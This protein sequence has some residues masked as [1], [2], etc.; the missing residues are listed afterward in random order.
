M[1]FGDSHGAPSQADPHD[2]LRVMAQRELAMLSLF[3]R[4][5]ASIEQRLVVL[6]PPN[7]RVP[8]FFQ[9][10]TADSSERETLLTAVQKL[11]G[12]VYLADGAIQADQLTK[13]GRHVTPEDAGA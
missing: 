2:P 11:R 4:Y 8:E 7:L 10:V 13:D 6:A 1:E 3:E 9:R 12:S 5:A